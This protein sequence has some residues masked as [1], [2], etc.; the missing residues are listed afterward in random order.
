MIRS[1]FAKHDAEGECERAPA[2]EVV[3]KGTNRSRFDAA[4]KQQ[5]V[6]L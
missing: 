6:Q 5:A 3:L 1:P 4:I 2:R